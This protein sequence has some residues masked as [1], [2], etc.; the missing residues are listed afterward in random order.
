M[1]Y[2]N[3]E[4]QGNKNICGLSRNLLQLSHLMAITRK[5]GF[6]IVAQAYNYPFLTYL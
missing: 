1:N 3:R 6:E 4:E 2:F 5:A